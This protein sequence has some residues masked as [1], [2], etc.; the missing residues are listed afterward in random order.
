MINFYERR[1]LL[2]F[3]GD[4]FM[5]REGKPKVATIMGE[6]QDRMISLR[7]AL[8]DFAE[9]QQK[10]EIIKTFK[11]IMEKLSCSYRKHVNPSVIAKDN[12]W[13]IARYWDEIEGKEHGIEVFKHK[14][15]TKEGLKDYRGYYVLLDANFE[16]GSFVCDKIGLD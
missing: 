9:T 4:M 2:F 11:E 10:E 14:K 16:K 5:E 7:D 12:K 8:I 3:E 15:L 6:V 1:G 13:I